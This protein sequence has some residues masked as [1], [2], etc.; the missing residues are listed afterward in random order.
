M[1]RWGSSCPFL[2]NSTRGLEPAATLDGVELGWPEPLRGLQS[3][4]EL[5]RESRAF[6]LGPR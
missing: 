5:A 4:V 1:T 3:A 2:S 6:P